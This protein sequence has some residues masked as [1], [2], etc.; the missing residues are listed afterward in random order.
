MANRLRQK[1]IETIRPELKRRFGIANDMAVPRLVK[2]SVNMGLGRAVAENNPRILEQGQKELTQLAGQLAVVTEARRA[3]SAF[4]TRE[5]YR[6]GARVTL[7]GGRMYDFFDRLINIAMPRIRDFRGFSV[8]SFDGRGNY[9]LGIEE[10]TI[11]P[12]INL[13]RV[14]FTQG[15]D[16][17]IVTTAKTDEQ[18]AVLLALFGFPFRDGSVAIGGRKDDDDAAGAA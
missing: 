3:V 11:F 17:A 13:D 18:G 14:E 9:S 12:E 16:V 5:G 1:Y 10:Q 15:M 6:V 2:I 4:K 7:R 8:K